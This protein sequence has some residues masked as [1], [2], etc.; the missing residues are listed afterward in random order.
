[1]SNIVYTE[2]EQFIMP[3]NRIRLHCEWYRYEVIRG[4]GFLLA[5]IEHGECIGWIAVEDLG[6]K[7]AKE[8]LE[9]G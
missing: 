4:H 8:W 7:T 2:T 1:M 9:R 3:E 5:V 6:F